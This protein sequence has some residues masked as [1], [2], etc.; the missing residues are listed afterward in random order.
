MK[1]SKI[2]DHVGMLLEDLQDEQVPI[3]VVKNPWLEVYVLC[4]GNLFK[5]QQN[6]RIQ[7]IDQL[8]VGITTKMISSLMWL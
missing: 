7:M 4:L 1:K 3:R 5:N 6:I 8:Q 2:I